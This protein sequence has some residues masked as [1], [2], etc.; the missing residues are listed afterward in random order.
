MQFKKLNIY[1]RHGGTFSGTLGVDLD[2]GEIDLKLNSDEV[3]DVLITCKESLK[4]ISK[5]AADRM[6]EAIDAAL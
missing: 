2:Q 3:R 1:R 4:R 5:E 6:Q